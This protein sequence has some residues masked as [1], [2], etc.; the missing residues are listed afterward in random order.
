VSILRG[1]STILTHRNADLDAVACA[2]VLYEI[3]RALGGNPKIVIPEGPS[4]HVLDFLKAYSI[5]L[6]HSTQ[7]EDVGRLIIVDVASVAQLGEYA[8]VI[9]KAEEVIVVDH[10]K[11]S[12]LPHNI[13]AYGEEAGSCC[14]L[15]VLLAR[16]LGVDIGR[17]CALLALAGILA[18]TNRLSR[19]YKTTCDA[20]SWIIEKYGVRPQD[21]R[22]ERVEDFA[23]RVARVRSL[24][25]LRAYRVDNLLLCLTHVGAFE[26]IVARTLLDAGCSLA[27]VFG[28]HEDVG[29]LRVLLR[30]RGFDLTNLVKTL[31]LRLGGIYGGHSE[32]SGIT[33]RGFKADNLEELYNEVLKSLEAL[34]GRLERLS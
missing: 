4:K 32:A 12:S 8:N 17:E 26:G 15:A 22:I 30:S 28:V 3:S 6:P 31:A 19:V 23:S 27:I 29:E 18:D 34:L 9:D 5:D 25:R 2:Y 10:H 20:L 11:I 7:L 13:V 21:L 16:D 14:E 1:S 24:L 33:I